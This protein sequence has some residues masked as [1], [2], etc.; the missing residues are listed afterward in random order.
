MDWLANLEVSMTVQLSPKK[1][2]VHDAAQVQLESVPADLQGA[3]TELLAAFE[4]AHDVRRARWDFAIGLNSLT[5]LGVTESNIRWMICQGMIEHARDLTQPADKERNL[6]LTP[7]LSFSNES[8]FV[9]SESFAHQLGSEHANQWIVLHPNHDSL[10]GPSSIPVWSAARRELRLGDYLIKRFRW[11]AK[12]QELILS[13]FEEEGW[14]LEG[15]FDPMPPDPNKEPKQRLRDTIKCLNRSQ[16]H[17]LIRFRGDGSGE[18]VIWEFT[19]E[20]TELL[21]PPQTEFRPVVR[22]TS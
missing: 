1:F 18:K 10:T 11:R 19:D 17:S 14:P 22:R 5:Q 20:A 16:E 6:V 2:A 13:T 4:M 9:L 8:C 3:I 7:A 15:V 21:A 12:N